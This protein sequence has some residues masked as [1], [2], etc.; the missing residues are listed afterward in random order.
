MT[1][2]ALARGLYQLPD[3]LAGQPTRR[4]WPNRPCMRTRVATG[5]PPLSAWCSRQCPRKVT[6]IGA[7]DQSPDQQGKGPDLVLTHYAIERRSIALRTPNVSDSRGHAADERAVSRDA[8]SRRRCGI[9]RCSGH[10]RV[11]PTGL[12]LM[13]C[14]SNVAYREE[15]ENVPVTAGHRWRSRTQC[16][17]VGFGETEPPAEWLDYPASAR[18]VGRR[19]ALRTGDGGSARNSRRSGRR[20][21]G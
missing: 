3:T 1:S 12:C 16:R 19:V 18:Q 4:A 2:S 9:G 13:S 20:T 11:L 8:R 21:A 17:H 6:N 5:R 15:N 10:G 7:S 14:T